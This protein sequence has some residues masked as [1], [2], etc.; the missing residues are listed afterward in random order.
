M[1]TFAGLFFAVLVLA[2]SSNAFAACTAR[3]IAHD[4]VY[5]MPRNT[6]LSI[7][8]NDLVLNDDD[9]DVDAGMDSLSAWFSGPLSAGTICGIGPD[10][11]CYRPP[12]NF[13]GLVS[14]PF[15][16]QDNCGNVDGSDILIFVQ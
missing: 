4:D 13:T 15:E 9:T 7:L 2:S 5:N 12:T 14:I 8:F 1:K 6:N 16:V 11:F 10:G 3:P